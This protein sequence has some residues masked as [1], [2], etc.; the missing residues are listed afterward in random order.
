VNRRSSNKSGK[1]P[2]RNLYFQLNVL[3]IPL[4]LL[5][6]RRAD[7]RELAEHFLAT[8]QIGPRPLHLAPEVIAALERY[9]WPGNIRELANVLERA[10]ILAEGGT[11]TLDDLPETLTRVP[12]SP[13]EVSASKFDLHAIEAKLLREVLAH[14]KGNRLAAARAFGISARTLY[15]MMD[16]YGI[17]DNA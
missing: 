9:E 10:Q 2:L 17:R 1:T 12:T 15:R 8:R 7:V 5:R 14:V 16:R 3:T 4:P 11:I 6:D 13:S